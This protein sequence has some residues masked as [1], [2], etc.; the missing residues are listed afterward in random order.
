MSERWRKS[1]YIWAWVVFEILGRK[2]IG[3]N[4][5]VYPFF[6]MGVVAIFE[7]YILFRFPYSEKLWIHEESADNPKCTQIRWIGLIPI[8]AWSYFSRI[9]AWYFIVYFPLT[10][11]VTLYFAGTE[12]EKNKVRADVSE[13]LKG[14][15]IM[16]IIVAAILVPYCVY[17]H[18]KWI[19]TMFN[20]IK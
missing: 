1:W 14:T 2:L 3:D 8:L 12:E 4:S 13:D 5:P 6:T 9:T 10:E 18:P 16:V 19:H 15:G 17:I 7:L 11:I 20:S